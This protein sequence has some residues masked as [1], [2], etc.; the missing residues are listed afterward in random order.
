MPEQVGVTELG[1][2]TAGFGGMPDEGIDPTL[3]DPTAGYGGMPK[4]AMT[5]EEVAAAFKEGAIGDPYIAN[6][7]AGATA[8]G[9]S[10]TPVFDAFKSLISNPAGRFIVGQVL[11]GA[12]GGLGGA[13]GLLNLLG[14]PGATAPGGIA[15]LAQQQA[16][17]IYY[18]DLPEFDV[19]K[20]FSPTLY[21]MRENRRT[22]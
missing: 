5:P 15:G 1:D 3:G 22:L 2:P 20:E 9:T 18:A 7:M 16:P 4:Q 21:A 19:T 14:R 17:Q 11:S 8:M 12:A 10:T 13:G 6:E